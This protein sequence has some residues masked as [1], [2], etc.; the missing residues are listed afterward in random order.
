MLAVIEVLTSFDVS[1]DQIDVLTLGCGADK[2][3]VS[4]E[5]AIGG[6][7]Q[8]RKIIEGAMRLQSLAAINQ[9]RLLLGPPAIV[10]IDAPT[11]TPKIRLD[12]WDRSARELPPAAASAVDEH[13]ERIMAFLREPAAPF[14]PEADS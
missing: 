10:R 4:N 2:F 12:D 11:F 14:T 8:W 7:W 9:S 5:Q 6:F 13:G 1:H 3:I